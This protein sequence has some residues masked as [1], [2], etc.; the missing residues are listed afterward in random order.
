MC[1]DIFYNS[2][3]LFELGYMLLMA[4]IWAEKDSAAHS[5]QIPQP[6]KPQTQDL[7]WSE[8]KAHVLGLWPWLEKEHLGFYSWSPGTT[9]DGR[10]LTV[11]IL[12]FGG[13]KGF[14]PMTQL[15]HSS[16]RS[17]RENV[18]EWVWLCSNNTLFTK[19]GDGP[20]GL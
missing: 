3:S 2:C 20:M 17:L 13:P 14:V 4:G 5:C 10:S 8:G 9:G 11:N 6:I 15:C 16:K 19:T 7:S 12:S 1:D 18:N